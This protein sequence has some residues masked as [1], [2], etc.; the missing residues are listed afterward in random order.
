MYTCVFIWCIDFNRVDFDV[1]R[2]H[3]KVSRPCIQGRAKKKKEEEIRRR[4]K[5]WRKRWRKR[6]RK[7]ERKKKGRR[8]EEE[9]EEEEEAEDGNDQKKK[10]KKTKMTRKTTD[11]T[12]KK[13]RTREQ[14]RALSPRSAQAKGYSSVKLFSRWGMEQRTTRKPKKIFWSFVHLLEFFVSWGERQPPI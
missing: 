13:K 14:D 1:A 4:R 8:K 9:R 3:R 6:R 10:K 11:G 2:P 12:K 5:R 7:K